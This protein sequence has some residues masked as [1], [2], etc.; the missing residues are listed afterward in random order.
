MARRLEPLCARHYR[1]A[2]FW[3]MVER[4]EVD[5]RPLAELLL[6][7]GKQVYLPAL[8]EPSAG[9][10]S[11]FRAFAGEGMLIPHRLGF[12]QPPIDALVATR[13]DFIVAPALAATR[14]GERLGYGAGH[15]DRALAALDGIEAAVVV[16]DDE[17]LDALPTEPHDRRVDWVVTEARM[18]GPT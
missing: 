8:S 3:P 16:Y 7:M 17:V 14:R 6:S 2:L 13:L 18:L 12:L 5:L 4:R 11:V 1:I 15:Y 10:A 9:Q